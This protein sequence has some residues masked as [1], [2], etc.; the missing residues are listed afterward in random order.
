MLY[1]PQKGIINPHSLVAY[2]SVLVVAY[3]AVGGR[4]TIWGAVLGAVAVGLLYEQLTSSWPEAWM[5]VLGGMFI[6]V[7]LL[8]PGGLLSL[9]QRYLKNFWA[10]RSAIADPPSQDAKQAEQPVADPRS[11]SPGAGAA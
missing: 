10:P 1:V 11:A 5:Y 7:P 4:G 8:L 2:A 6:A 9:W 3:V